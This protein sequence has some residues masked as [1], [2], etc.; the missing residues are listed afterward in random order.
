MPP[1]TGEIFRAFLRLGLTSFGG[2]IAHLEY[3]RREFVER[4]RWLSDPE[5][6]QLLAVSQFLPG[7][8]SSQLGF[9]IGLLRGGTAGAIAAFTAF[10][11]PSALLLFALATLP[12]PSGAA[13]VAVVLH[14]LKLVAAVVVLDG[15]TR[16]ARS[17]TP[18]APRI[19][20]AVVTAVLVTWLGA[21]WVQLVAIA[22]AGVVGAVA[23]RS[24][25]PPSTAA[26]PI[27]AS[28]SRGLRLLAVFALGTLAAVLWPP[29]SA[30]LTALAATMWR[31]GALVFGG[32]HVVLPLLE[33]GTVAS[34]WLSQEY[35]LSG[36]G[37][38]QLVPGPMFSF[39]AFLGAAVPTGAAP[40][41]SAAVAVLAI[42]APGFLLIGAALPTWSRIVAHP[43]AARAVSGINA[44]V[45][46]LLAAAL[47][48]PV[49]PAALVSRWD[50]AA[51]AL[52]FALQ[53]MLHRPTLAVFTV[54]LLASAWIM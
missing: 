39:A 21:A 28:P 40:W 6:A 50:L 22:L 44:A 34:G 54:C 53:R 18:D 23:L 17:L 2:P 4:R 11:L 45:V 31:A 24:T 35:F 41:I 49:L 9:G 43:T 30:S 51:L 47:I 3:F 13:A 10:T 20:I 25:P 27:A 7:P 46:G 16:M 12:V 38:A 29:S 37:A 33:E 8:A 36:Y 15:V 1:H 14:A 42:F 52:G 19:A 5:F 32:G 26:L 48:D